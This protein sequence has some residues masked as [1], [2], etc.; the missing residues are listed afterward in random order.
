[1]ALA[2]AGPY[3]RAPSHSPTPR[4]VMLPSLRSASRALVGAVFIIG[5]GAWIAT[6]PAA[7]A[8]AFHLRLVKSEP[9]KGDTVAS[10]KV[11]RLWFSEPATLAV[12]SIKLKGADGKEIAVAKPT[13][14]GDA[15]Q[16][17]EAAVTGGLVAG[18][19]SLAYKTASKDM[20][21]ITGE[22]TFV[23]R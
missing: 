13:F 2:C 11:V 6:T 3:L 12:T 14:S 21:P 5:T 7:H 15:R 1:M 23:V 18:K 16:P 4:T 17:V 19:Y 8:E 20:H 9:S 10:P 22:F